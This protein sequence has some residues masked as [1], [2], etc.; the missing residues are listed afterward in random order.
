M[1]S[2]GTGKRISSDRLVWTLTGA[3]LLTGILM[4]FSA[5]MSLE[6][7]RQDR[8]V[9]DR[10]MSRIS[11]AQKSVDEW[12]GYALSLSSDLLKGTEVSASKLSRLSSELEE[13]S[14]KCATV[15]PEKRKLIVARLQSFRHYVEACSHFAQQHRRAESAR[16]EAIT[17]C[18]ECLHNLTAAFE[19]RR[20]QRMLEM[21][22]EVRRYRSSTGAEASTAAD[23]VLTK[24]LPQMSRQAD[25]ELADL[26]LLGERLIGEADS[27]NLFDIKDNLLQPTLARLHRTLD[28][29]DVSFQHIRGLLTKYEESL[30]GAGFQRDAAHQSLVP[31]DGGLYTSTL[32]YLNSLESRDL[33][34]VEGRERADRLNDVQQFLQDEADTLTS[35]LAIRAERS[36]GSAWSTMATLAAMCSVVFIVLARRIAATIR[37]QVAAINTQA[38]TLQTEMKERAMA[39]KDRELLNQRLQQAARQAGMAEVATG[40]LHN[41]GNVLNSVNVSANVISEKNNSSNVSILADAVAVLQEHETSLGS[42]IEDDPRGKHLPMLLTQISEGLIAEQNKRQAE[43]DSMVSNV[44]HIKSIVAMQQSLA[45]KGGLIEPVRPHELLEQ[46]LKL[47]QAS[48][49][50]HGVKLTQ[51]FNSSATIMADKHQVL[52]ILVNLIKNGIEAV[53]ETSGE[54]RIEVSTRDDGEYLEVSVSDSGVGIAPDNL[55]KIFQHG[56]TTKEDGHGFGLHSCANSAQQAGGTLVAESN[57]KGQGATFTL[58]LPIYRS[59]ESN[60]EVPLVGALV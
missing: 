53:K 39:E 13:V 18:S 5:R 33:L 54:G 8:A 46:T 55:S 58:R 57:G 10:V 48:L 2:I 52:Q 36:I 34:T 28:T 37:A 42:F 49:I 1:R 23:M 50:R 12:V 20:G 32:G 29:E 27:D 25:K 15:E 11:G 14:E 38:V 59:T 9:R 56:F 43:L 21:A 30:F 24:M 3:G 60:S 31:G 16:S 4:L 47:N 41:V 19:S 26:A 40:V 6:D 45:S 35:A 22:Q 44:E 17:R 51:S 7:I